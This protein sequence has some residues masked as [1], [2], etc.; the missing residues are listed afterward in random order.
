MVLEGQKAVQYA[1]VNAEP[2]VDKSEKQALWL[3][4]LIILVVFIMLFFPPFNIGRISAKISSNLTLLTSATS[5]GTVTMKLGAF[6]QGISHA[7][8]KAD[9]VWSMAGCAMVLV[10]VLLSAAGA[11]LSLGNRKMRRLAIIFP[12][13]GSVLGLAGLLVNGLA[14]N[15]IVKFINSLEYAD[16]ARTNIEP[17]FPTFAYITMGIGLLA[18]LLSSIWLIRFTYRRQS[19]QVAEM[20]EKYKLF[21]MFLPVLLLA[22]LFAYLPIYGWRY[23]FYDTKAGAELTSD[24]F[25]GFRNFTTLIRDPGTRSK[26]VQVLRNTLVM[27]GLGIA[28][29]WLPIAFAILLAEVRSTKFQRGVQTLT[30]IP[31]FLSW[32]LVYAVALSIFSSDGLINNVSNLIAGSNVSNEDYLANDNFTWIKMLLWGTWKGLGWSSIIYVAGIA[33]IDQQLYEAARVDGAN[34][35]HCIWHITVPGL[36]PTY[37]V[38]LLMSIAGILSNGMEQYLVFSNQYN[39]DH[40]QVLDLYVYNLGIGSSQ[41]AVSTVVGILKSVVAVVLLFG[42]NGISKAVRGESII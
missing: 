25:V 4:R 41:L 13:I 37:M 29:S 26:I 11:C 31:N 23:A 36:I 40:I 32:V 6:M 27:S 9:I 1:A 2:A 34:R 33:G 19:A 14:Y 24:L 20:P 28:T 18:I 7:I 16:T 22:F 8:N 17:I 21:I 42:A 5:F 38:M 35:F 3:N 10:G 15:S 12:L 39:G 30:T